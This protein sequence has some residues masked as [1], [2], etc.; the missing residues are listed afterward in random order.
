MKK[1]VGIVGSYRKGHV[2]DDAVSEVLR[3]AESG[4]AEVSKIYLVDK[5]IE[6][7]N[8]CRNCMQN[9]GIKR[10]KCVFNDEMEDILKQIDQADAVVIGS[11]MNFGTVT[12]LT[13]RFIERLICY[14]YWPWGTAMPK[15]R[16]KKP[17]KKAVVITSSCMPS[18]I[19]KILSAGDLGGCINL[20]KK[21]AKTMGAKTQTD[22]WFGLAA[23]NKEDGL[24][25]KGKAKAFAAGKRLV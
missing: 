23:K 20:L 13:K 12:A 8:N 19:G 5:N 2:I 16:V 21:A 18:L 24:D 4:G 17:T 7:C 10:G 3:G 14:A 25:D 22:L 1:V 15:F 9:E 11:P 6:F